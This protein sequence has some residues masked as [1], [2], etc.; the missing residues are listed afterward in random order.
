MR[1]GRLTKEPPRLRNHAVGWTQKLWNHITQVS[2]GRSAVTSVVDEGVA[3]GPLD[4]SGTRTI[5]LSLTDHHTP[6]TPVARISAP[7]SE[8]T[9]P[10]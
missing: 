1:K 10:E 9:A 4:P 6:M 5:A 3:P 7:E 2:P 8:G